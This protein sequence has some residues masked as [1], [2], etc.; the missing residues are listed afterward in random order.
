MA[1]EK[2]PQAGVFMWNE[3]GTH[4]V[5]ATRKFYCDAIGWTA[6]EMDVGA[7]PYT[8]FMTGDTTVGGCF[9]MEGP[10]LENVP[11]HWMAYVAVDDVDETCKS[12]TAA[13]GTVTRAPFDIPTVGRIAIIMDPMG[14]VLG[15]MTP[16][17]EAS[18]S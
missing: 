14:A 11:Q 12:V 3:V 16:S 13:G 7:G 2:A 15:L 18:G 1:E 6:T 8:L 9:R 10:E 4:D 17:G 5:E